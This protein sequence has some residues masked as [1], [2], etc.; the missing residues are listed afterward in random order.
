MALTDL[1]TTPE[2]RRRPKGDGPLEPPA[3]ITRL[4]PLLADRL[5]D[6]AVPDVIDWVIAAGCFAIFTLPVLLGSGPARTAGLVAAFGA[7]AAVPLIVRR[8][9]PVA[10]V[11]I[12]DGDQEPAPRAAARPGQGALARLTDRDRDV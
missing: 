2:P 10:V 3:W 5:A 1:A 6:R 4:W 12:V 8:K 11:V 9:W 7:M